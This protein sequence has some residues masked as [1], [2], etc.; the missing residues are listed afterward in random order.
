MNC[1]VA[2]SLAWEPS[3]G[4]QLIFGEAVALSLLY[5]GMR[6]IVLCLVVGCAT[7]GRAPSHEVMLD[8]AARFT[9]VDG[10]DT[11]LAAGSYD[12]AVGDRLLILIDASGSRSLLAAEHIAHEF[13]LVAD[14][15]VYVAGDPPTIAVLRV[16]GSGLSASRSGGVRARGAR[17]GFKAALRRKKALGSGTAPAPAVNT[18]STPNPNDYPRWKY[19]GADH[20]DFD[21]VEFEA[22]A[23]GGFIRAHDDHVE[24]DT[25]FYWGTYGYQRAPGK[26]LATRLL[27]AA[28]LV[29]LQTAFSSPD[30]KI[31]VRSCTQEY[32]GDDGKVH[33]SLRVV[34]LGVVRR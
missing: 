5:A 24:P 25:R 33:E 20:G 12:V 17:T 18:T 10:T 21:L 32:L 34:G 8:E 19:V 30:V 26:S 28:E 31:V 29:A 6:L 15:A 7:T 1:G 11:T 23:T 2:S 27:S 16:D 3:G 22:N 13:S 14:T 9:A 4:R